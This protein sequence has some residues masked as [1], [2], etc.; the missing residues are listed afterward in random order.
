MILERGE[1]LDA[2][3]FTLKPAVNSYY[4][5]IWDKSDSESL[6]NIGLITSGLEEAATGFLV[7]G[8]VTIDTSDTT[9]TAFN[10]SY[11]DFNK[12]DKKEISV[13]NNVI[14]YVGSNAFSLE[15]NL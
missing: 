1:T 8:Y 11:E 9:L 10:C 7:S 4:P 3:K 15:K 14:K 12:N 6:Q 2:T 13:S 5:L